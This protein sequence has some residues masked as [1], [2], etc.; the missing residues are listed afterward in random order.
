MSTHSAPEAFPLLTRDGD[1]LGAALTLPD[2]NTALAHMNGRLLPL[3]WAKFLWYRRRIEACRVLA[4]GVKPEY[5]D[6]GIAAALYI[7]HLNGDTVRFIDGSSECFD[8][9]VWATGDET[10]IPFLASRHLP[11]RDGVPEA[12]ILVAEHVGVPP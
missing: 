7:E 6:L 9:I 10:S 11:F 1:L 12:I 3:G 2:V 5:Q 4:L 8:T